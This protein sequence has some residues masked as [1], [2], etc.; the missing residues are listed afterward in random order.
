LWSPLRA[1]YYFELEGRFVVE[2]IEP[3]FLF[4]GRDI[5]MRFKARR[6]K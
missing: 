6:I 5:Y 3:K 1:K 4:D 2:N